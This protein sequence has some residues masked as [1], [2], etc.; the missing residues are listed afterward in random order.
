MTTHDIVPSVSPFTRDALAPMPHCPLSGDAYDEYIMRVAFSVFVRACAAVSPNDGCIRRV[1]NVFAV[2]TL[3]VDLTNTAVMNG[4][5]SPQDGKRSLNL[6][7]DAVRAATDRIESD[8]AAARARV[9]RLEAA[10]ETHTALLRL[11]ASGSDYLDMAQPQRGT[12]REMLGSVLRAEDEPISV[13]EMTARMSDAFGVDIP[14][15][16]VSPVLKRMEEDGDVLHVGRKWKFNEKGP[17]AATDGPW[18]DVATNPTKRR[19]TIML[20]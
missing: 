5:D 11:F 1:S 10:L 20:G 3:A 14:R 6:R 8:L 9:K 2:L 17:S 7:E 13:R 12:I 4:P 18:N 16:S 19:K 15:T